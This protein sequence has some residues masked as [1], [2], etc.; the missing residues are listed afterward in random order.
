MNGKQLHNTTPDMEMDK[1]IIFSLAGL[2]NS[3]Q[4]RRPDFVCC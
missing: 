3:E 2:D 4:L 1:E